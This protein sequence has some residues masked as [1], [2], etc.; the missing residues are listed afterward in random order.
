MTSLKNAALR[1]SN[2]VVDI[3]FTVVFE[4]NSQ[5]NEVGTGMFPGVTNVT[6]YFCGT[7]EPATVGSYIFSTNDN[8]NVIIFSNAG[9]SFLGKPVN[10]A[11][12]CFL[13]QRK[14]NVCRTLGYRRKPLIEVSIGYSF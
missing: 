1:H 14:M 2:S 4:G 5:L 11:S 9:P 12:P 7:K 13:F 6:I 3:S 8:K 10:G